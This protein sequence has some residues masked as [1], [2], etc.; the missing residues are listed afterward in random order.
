MKAIVATEKNWGIGKGGD[1]LIHLPGDL[2]F[3]RE[4]TMGKVLIMG[5]KTLESLPGSRPLD[6]RTTIVLT[7]DE[8]YRPAYLEKLDEKG[9]ITLK[10]GRKVT[11]GTCILAKSYDEMMVKLLALEAS[12]GIDIEEDVYVAGGE[13]IYE[14][15]FPYCNEFVVTRIDKAID[16]DRFFPNLD[17]KVA[18]GSMKILWESEPCRD[19]KTGAEYKFVRY[20]TVK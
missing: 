14:M 19:E 12:E 5:R 6:G 11:P 15:M 17:S 10:S 16:A 4:Q 7:R 13:S 3:F 1:L 18:D 8:N 2:E 9:Q 20:A